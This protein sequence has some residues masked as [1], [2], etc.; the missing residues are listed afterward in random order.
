MNNYKGEGMQKLI[1]TDSELKQGSEEW[2][3]FRSYGLGGSEISVLMNANP[4]KSI[5]DLWEIKTGRKNDGFEINE[6]IQQGKDLEPVAKAYYEEITGRK[7]EPI[8]MVH[9]VY[10]WMRT[11]LD[12]LSEDGKVILEIKVPF[13]QE[14][15]HKQATE[16]QLIDGVK[17]RVPKRNV[18][19]WR[20][21]QLQHQLAVV[22]AHFGAERVDYF[23]YSHEKPD[24][25][26]CIPI[27]PDFI[28]IQELIKR[29][30]IFFGYVERDE[31]PPA[32]LFQSKVKGKTIGR[33]N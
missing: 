30:E 29:E 7:M 24:T 1:W 15:H 4:W 26:V 27:R 11:S 10:T 9:P 31:Q 22:M 23:S 13:N 16:I 5:Q 25:S 3:Q 2:L 28:Y 8:C 21:P 32:D 14:N 19:T 18:P 33:R 6:A 20:Y 17:V 12:G